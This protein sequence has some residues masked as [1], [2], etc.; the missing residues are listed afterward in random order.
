MNIQAWVA[1]TNAT[2]QPG[3]DQMSLPEIFVS[4]RSEAPQ[5]SLIF[6][7]HHGAHMTFLDGLGTLPQLSSF[8]LESVQRVKEDADIELR[9]LFPIA[10]QHGQHAHIP[11]FDPTHLVQLGSFAIPKGPEDRVLQQFNIDAPTTRDN[12]MRV[13]RAC[14]VPKPIL[15]EG[16]PGVGK[17]SLITALANITGHRLCRINLSDQTDLVDLFGSDLPVEGGGPG[18]F[19]WKDAEF[20]KALQDG[21]WVLLDEMNLAPQMVLEGLNAILD[22]RGT[23]YIPELGRS[24]TRHPAFRIFAA[25]NPLQQGGGRKGLPKSFINRFTKVYVEELSTNDM[26]LVSRHLF[27]DCDPDV[28]RLMIDYN[29]RLSVEMASKNLFAKAGSP[30]EFNLR[31]I[32]RWGTLVRHVSPLQHPAAFLRS[33]YLHRFRTLED[34]D[35]A[36]RLFDSIFLYSSRSHQSAPHVSLSPEHIQIGC[37]NLPRGNESRSSRPRRVLQIQQSALESAGLCVAQ[38]WLAIVTGSHDSGKTDLVRSLAGITGNHLWEISM[39]NTT[40]AMDILG[41]FEQVDDRV[42]VLQVAEQV[43]RLA[44]NAFRNTSLSGVAQTHDYF[45][46]RN[47][48]RNQSSPFSRSDILHSASN[49]L[50]ELGRLFRDIE[51][52]QQELQTGVDE[53]VKLPITVGRFEWV[54]GPLV[55][56]LRSG[57]WLLLD[58]ANLCNP[59]VLDRLN[60]LCEAGGVLT[61]SE[62][63]Y[64]NGK[65]QTIKPHP[66]FRLFMT[67]NPQYGELSRAMRNRGLEIA[68]IGSA[69]EEDQNRLRDQF[70]IPSRYRLAGDWASLSTSFDHIRRGLVGYRTGDPDTTRRWSSGEFA[71]LDCP[72]L[73]LMDIGSIL[74]NSTNSANTQQGANDSILFL[75]KVVPPTYALYCRRY[76]LRL[77]ISSSQFNRILEVLQTVSEYQA[78]PILVRIKEVYGTSWGVPPG[79]IFA[80][81]SIPDTHLWL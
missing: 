41:S 36:Q 44:D 64:V 78:L 65:I 71:D 73:S 55:R 80:Q 74:T 8:S 63:G 7:Q 51:R 24:F 69:G 2:Y 38:S 42:R 61:L 40:D 29:S 49:I 39:S 11:A 15:L 68:L 72:S 53:L 20:L 26:I 37:L 77:G 18:E 75:S 13:V 1:F 79:F 22:H 30:W 14:Q 43:L 76:F 45:T 28:L 58:G 66:N 17:T 70:R 23:V 12:A 3:T 60:S 4:L 33:A 27:P 62:R 57:Q 34:R 16:S 32:I 6:L 9:E 25:Q 48:V 35:Y 19:A 81:V 21:H 67:V 56:A 59:S 31:D 47:T 10:P 52:E 5:H 54:D 50:R 46:L